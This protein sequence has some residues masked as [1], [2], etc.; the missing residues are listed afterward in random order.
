MMR[1]ASG[2]DGDSLQASLAALGSCLAVGIHA[3]ARGITVC[4]FEI[5]LEGD[6]NITALWGTGDLSAKP[7]GLTDVAAA[8][9]RQFHGAHREVA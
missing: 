2:R 4:R 8:D 1:H 7:V 5:E 3:V 9:R 6:L